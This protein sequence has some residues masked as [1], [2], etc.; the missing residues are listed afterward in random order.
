[1]TRFICIILLCLG[2]CTLAWAQPTK[3]EIQKKQQELQRELSELNKT[4]AEIKNNKKASLAELA[5]VQRKI[6]AREELINNISRELRRLD[7]EIYLTQLEMNRLRREL[8]TLKQQYAKSLVFAYKNRSNYD[9]LNFLFSA[10]SFN[11]A[12]KRVAYL[13]SYRQYRETQAATIAQTQQLLVQKNQSLANSK[14]DKSKTLDEQNNQ[15]NV[16]EQDRSEQKKVVQQ[17]QGREKEIAKQVAESEK[18]RQRLRQALAAIIRREEEEARKAERQRLAKLAEEER[19][20]KEA[21]KNKPNTATAGTTKPATSNNPPLN[22]PPVES[23]SRPKTD[24]TYNV[25]E[26]TPEGLTLSLNFESNRGKLPWPVSEGVVTGNFGVQKVS[27]GVNRKY[28]GITITCKTNIPVRCVADGIVTSILELGGYQCVVVRHGKY[29]SVYSQVD[30]VKV[31]KGQ[32]VKAGT[33]LANVA[34]VADDEFELEFQVMNN[35]NG[36]YENPTSWLKPR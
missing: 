18:Q 24:R 12:V 17:L 15:L 25:F 6:K 27:A 29:L 28:D 31:S 10:Q 35:G 13:K 4:L 33:L 3:E 23:G 19:R 26:S 22:N 20:R 21:E 34:E 16:L 32:E 2:S 5:V 11:D 7:D 14:Q 30:G 36:R 9:Y 1:M 8:D